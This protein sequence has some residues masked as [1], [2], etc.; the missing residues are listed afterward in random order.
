LKTTDYDKVIKPT[1]FGNEARCELDTRADTCCAGVNCRPIFFTGQRCEVHGFH[2]EFEPLADVPVATVATLW[3]DPLTGRGYVLIIHE[4]LYF[5]SKMDHSLIN[6][7]QLRHYGIVVHDN[8]YERDHRRDMGIEIDETD[9]LPFHS[10]GSMVFFTTRYPS[11][12]EL[13]MYPHVTVTCDAPWDPHS[14]LMPGGLDETGHPT[15]DRE[16]RKVRSNNSHGLNRHHHMYETDRVLLSV[17]GNTDR[18]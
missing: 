1:D 10:Q 5:G 13:D 6:P 2:D 14:L 8:P 15:G 7:N 9:R 11:D 12:D 18:A 17:D 4:T 3:T 16:I